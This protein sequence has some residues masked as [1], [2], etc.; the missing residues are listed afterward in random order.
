MANGPGER[1]KRVVFVGNYLPRQCGIATFT[2]D[3]C[4]NLAAIAPGTSFHVV[5]MNDRRD[6]Y[7]YPARV[8]FEIPDGRRPDYDTAADYI[9]L[10]RPDVIC[11]QHEYGIYGGRCGRYLLP[12]LRQVYAPI[13]T[14]LHTVLKDP[15]KDQ[16]QV[17]CELA[18]L[19][20]Q[21]VVMSRQ[22]VEFLKTVYGVPEAKISFIHHGIPD[23][24]FVD[25]NY[26]KDRFKAEGR[27][28]VLTFGLLGP[29][30]G[31]EIAIDAIAEVARE[32]PN[33]LYLVVG[34]THP[35]LKRTD[36]EQYRHSL[37]R[38]VR[39]RGLSGHV[40]FVDRF[41]DTEELCEYIGGADIYVT[42]Y[43]SE[44]QITSGTLA[45]AM[46]MGKAVVSTPYWY[47]RELLA[48]DRGRLFPFG[49]SHAL[50]RI[51]IELLRDDAARHAL[52]KRAYN[53]GRAMVWPRIAAQYLELFEKVRTERTH[54][55]LPV[56]EPR[57]EADRF[58]SLPELNPAHLL[59]MTDGTG[60]LQHARYGVPDLRHGYCTDDQAR[61]L[62]VA[63]KAAHRQPESTVWDDL[64][65]RY[66]AFLSYAFDEESERF[67]N[68]LSY[69]RTWTKPGATEDVHGRTLWGLAHTVSLSRNESHRGLAAHLIERSLPQTHT[70]TS[71]RAMA[72]TILAA[73]LYLRRYRGASQIRAVRDTLANRLL[74]QMQR[75]ATDDWPWLE[76]SLT[77]ANAR[78]PHALIEAGQALGHRT[79]LDWGLKA[80]EWLD[81][82]QTSERGR[83]SP[84]GSNGWYRRGGTMARFDQQPIEAFTMLDACVAAYRATREPRWAAAGRRAFQWFLGENDLGLPLYDYATGACFDG[85][86]ADRVN[87][88]QGAE[89]TIC[90]LLSLIL[91]YELQEELNDEGQR[92]LSSGSPECA[93]G[94]AQLDGVSGGSATA[95]SL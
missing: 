6:G 65:S 45:Y 34:A 14:T 68:F 62:I 15:D 83:F 82:I 48:E 26:F 78:I 19:S 57:A 16:K 92:R 90:W 66:L 21:L 87:R 54:A 80:L 88:N 13:V 75:N 72:L 81:R 59:R 9:N 28:V 38:R 1:L 46:G 10:H 5:A 95:S 86:H 53:F 37:L 43:L 85:L 29:N 91:M 89:S 70:F 41:V 47:A 12:M 24:P 36:G 40:L 11:V 94:S 51:L 2:T 50:S 58:E 63:T 22:A 69:Q 79:M 67:G 4:E 23:T 60:I 44:A 71:P 61:A 17:L 35:N 7:E 8:C 77:Y 3:L 56:R 20:D 31:I 39:E 64:A 30:K 25:P 55:P 18:S 33:V 74:E 42:P 84:V 52:R 32:C 49:D 73:Q 93:S 76:D 27:P